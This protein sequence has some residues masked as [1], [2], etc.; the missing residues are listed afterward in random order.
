MQG[1]R[2]PR[3]IPA[4]Y[5]VFNLNKL[6]EDGL[7]NAGRINPSCKGGWVDVSQLRVGKLGGD[8]DKEG[9]AWRLSIFLSDLY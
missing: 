8:V 1:R 7:R 5:L 6:R 9:A 2:I 4:D 3:G